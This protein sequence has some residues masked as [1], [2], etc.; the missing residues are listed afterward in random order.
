[1]LKM[2]YFF[3]AYVTTDYVYYTIYSF[4]VG[5]NKVMVLSLEWHKYSS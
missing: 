2:V 1:M 5:N 4:G 3:Q